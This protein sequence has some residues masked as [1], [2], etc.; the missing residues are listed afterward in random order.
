VGRDGDIPFFNSL[1]ILVQNF[2]IEVI[3]SIPGDWNF[4]PGLVIRDRK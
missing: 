3:L 2:L 4:F 1:A